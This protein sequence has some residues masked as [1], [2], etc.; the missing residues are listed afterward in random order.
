[1]IQRPRSSGSIGQVIRRLRKRARMKQEA[2]AELIGVT[3]PTL[4]RIETDERL[5]T[6]VQRELLAQA[7]G[8]GLA[9]L[10]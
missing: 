8:C 3:Q 10:T 7:L 9:D 4:S 2:L 1:M 5:P 6:D